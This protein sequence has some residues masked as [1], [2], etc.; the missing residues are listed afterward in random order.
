ME[1]KENPNWLCIRC[2]AS[3][4]NI[5]RWNLFARGEGLHQKSNSYEFSIS[6]TNKNLIHIYEF[7]INKIYNY[8]TAKN[9]YDASLENIYPW[10]P[11]E[12]RGLRQKS[13]SYDFS[14]SKINKKYIYNIKQY[15]TTKKTQ[16]DCAYDAYDA[17]ES[18][19]K[20]KIM[21]YTDIFS[22]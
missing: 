7:S 9:A 5:C 21:S 11:S 16:N 6:K 3:F 13:N 2:T 8:K 14:I 1:R 15:K 10:K 17:L 19:Y 20:K 4:D 22:S 18:L 12:K